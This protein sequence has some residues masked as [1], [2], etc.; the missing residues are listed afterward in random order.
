MPEW[1][2]DG[3]E[4]VLDFYH[5][6]EHFSAVFKELLGEQTEEYQ[7]RHKQWHKPFPDGNERGIAELKHGRGCKSVYFSLL[8]NNASMSSRLLY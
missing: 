5:A 7:R 2:N 8:Q 1:A 3:S 6:T 4:I